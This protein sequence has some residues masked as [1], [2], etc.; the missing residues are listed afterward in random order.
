MCELTF[1]N[2]NEIEQQINLLKLKTCYNAEDKEA[3][4]NAMKATV[5]F[6]KTRNSLNLKKKFYFETLGFLKIKNL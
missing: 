5:C 1:D 3:I 4:R 2:D 6:Y